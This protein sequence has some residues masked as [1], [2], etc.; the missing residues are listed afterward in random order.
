MVTA[1]GEVTRALLLAHV[2]WGQ[3]ARVSVRDLGDMVALGEGQLRRLLYLLY[4]RQWIWYDSDH[5]TVGLTASG[6]A[7]F[8][9][10]D[11][12]WCGTTS[13][14]SLPS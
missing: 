8:A 9:G 12:P 1:V 11:R 14:G 3:R 7:V 13:S 4:R 10:R 2:V 5:A 6:V